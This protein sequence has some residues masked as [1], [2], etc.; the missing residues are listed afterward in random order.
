MTDP[1]LALRIRRPL[2][3]SNSTM[4]KEI[5]SPTDKRLRAI[6]ALEIELAMTEA[7]AQKLSVATPNLADPNQQPEFAALI[8]EEKER[9]ETLRRQIQ[10]LRDQS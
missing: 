1:L 7:H 10:L 3:T 6:A 8:N 4:E 9:A 5:P 2:Y